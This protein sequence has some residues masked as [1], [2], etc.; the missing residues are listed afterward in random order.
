MADF[1]KDPQA[2]LDYKVDWAA[3]A[4]KGGPFLQDGE[5]I[6]TSTWT[7]QAGITKGSDTKDSTSATVWVSGGTADTEY[8]LTNT[9]TT[10]LGRTDKRTITLLVQA[11]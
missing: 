11:K 6:A 3:P 5:T 1:I 9:V 10:S 4:A 8:A 2:V 7:V